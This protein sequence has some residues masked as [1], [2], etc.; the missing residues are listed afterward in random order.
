[1]NKEL[2]KETL[3]KLMRYLPSKRVYYATI[4]EKKKDKSDAIV[5]FDYDKQQYYKVVPI[6]LTDDEISI[7]MNLAKVQELKTI[8]ICLQILASLA[9]LGVTVSVIL[10]IILAS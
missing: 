9:V 4:E 5:N 1:M 6:E 2:K 3:N 7:V 8:R 10:G